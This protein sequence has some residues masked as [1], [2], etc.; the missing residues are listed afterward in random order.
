MNVSL[1]AAS[2]REAL[3]RDFINSL[4]QENVSI[5]VIFAGHKPPKEQWSL[6]KYITTSYIKPSQAYE[7]CRRKAKG[8]V[9]V[10]CADDCSFKG[11][12]LT[13]A[14][15]Y[16]K[17]QNNEKLILSIQTRETGYNLPKGKLFDM[18]N[19]RFFGYRKST[20]LMAP[21]GM[22]GRKFLDD[23]GGFDRRYVCGQYENDVVMRAYANGGTVKIFGNEYCFIDIDHLGKSIKIGES[24]T[25]DDF[26][27][28]PF[29]TGYVKDRAVL[30]AS[31]ASGTSALTERRDTFEPYEDKDILTVSQ[32]NRGIW[33]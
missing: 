19:H 24:K 14:Y 6:L 21:L 1:I 23:L 31:W 32:S 13:R 18:D 26:L 28:R 7:I 16:W 12:I 9:I 22:M 5:E 27:N 4:L 15:T 20:P 10:W 3:Y 30:E 17:S 2:I 8:E 25:E 33:E 11:Q 29:A